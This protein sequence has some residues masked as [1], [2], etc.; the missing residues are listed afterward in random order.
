MTWESHTLYV[1][2]DVSR[3]IDSNGVGQL[4]PQG[5]IPMQSGKCGGRRL[6]DFKKPRDKLKVVS[7]SIKKLL[8]PGHLNFISSQ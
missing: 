4:N 8:V 5:T 3:T 1:V 7:G 2:Y 6:D